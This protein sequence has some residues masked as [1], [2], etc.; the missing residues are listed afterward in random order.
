FVRQGTRQPDGL[1]Y[2]S[3]VRRGS[4]RKRNQ[5]VRKSYRKCRGLAETPPFEP[6]F[7]MAF[8]MGAVPLGSNLKLLS[9]HKLSDIGRNQVALLA[10][11]NLPPTDLIR[12]QQAVVA[13]GHFEA[14]NYWLFQGARPE[15]FNEWIGQHQPQFQAWLD[16]LNQNMISG[17][18][19]G[20]S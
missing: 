19:S 20:F 18:L 9:I 11:K 10:Q 6:Q 3:V 14:Y 16:W 4:L 8:L 5:C 17:V 13:A 12:W 15:E 2:V 1:F 7:E